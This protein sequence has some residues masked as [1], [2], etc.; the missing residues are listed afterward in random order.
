MPVYGFEGELY[1]KV[2]GQD[3][4]G[5]YVELQNCTDVEVDDTFNEADVT[6][7][8]SGGV[9]QTEPTTRMIQINFSMIWE[10]S[11]PDFAAFRTAAHARQMIAIRALDGGEGQQ[12]DYKLTQFKRSSPLKGAVTV[13]VI[14]KPCRSPNPPVWIQP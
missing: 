14:L 1:Y 8:G 3:A 10:P 12:A 5:P 2:G 7:R 4:G 13:E 6:T 11:D 9:D